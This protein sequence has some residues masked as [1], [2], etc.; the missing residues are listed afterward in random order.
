MPVYAY[1]V[2]PTNSRIPMNIANR[3]EQPEKQILRPNLPCTV[4][5]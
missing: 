2:N 5:L 1:S 3:G 4:E